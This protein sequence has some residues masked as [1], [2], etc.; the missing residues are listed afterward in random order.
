MPDII[1]DSISNDLGYFGNIW[2][3]S[4]VLPKNGD[5]NGGGHLHP[6]DHVTMLHKGRVRVDV[7]DPETQE[8]RSK[9]FTAPTFIVIRKNLKHKFTALEDDVQ[10]YCV[11]ALRDIDGEVTDIYSGNNDPYNTVPDDYW[12]KKNLEKLDA[13]TTHEDDKG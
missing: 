4:H 7:T 11:F 5:V 12:I 8:R 9:E 13:S 10:Y 1:G 6:H 3:R 2:V